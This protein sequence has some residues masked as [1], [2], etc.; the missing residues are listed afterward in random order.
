MMPTQDGSTMHNWKKIRYAQ[1]VFFAIGDT[2]ARTVGADP[3]SGPTT[4]AATSFDGVVWTNRELAS[5][6]SWVAVAFGNPYSN[7]RDSTVGKKTPMWIAIPNSSDKFNRIQ[8]GAR[9]LGRAIITAGKI[10]AIRLWDTG[11]GYTESPDVTIVDPFNTSDAIV[12]CRMGD[13]VLTNPTWINRGLGYRT[14]ST[15][16]TITG[17]GYADVVPAGKF[18]VINDLETYPGPGAQLTIQGLDSIYT[19]VTVTPIGQ[20]DRGL[21]A[22]VRV[23]PEI[24]NRD[25]LSHLRPMTIRTKFSQ[26]RITGHDFLDIGTGNF[27]E[28]NYPNLYS[29]FYTP[30]PENEI[31]EEDGGR[32]FYTS[33]DQS[34]N[35]RTGELFAVEQATGTV[36]ISAD[37]FDFSGL[38]ELRLGGIRVG[39]TGAVVR[40]FSTDPSFTEDSNNVVPTQRAIRAYLASRLSIGGSE[41]AV[42]S[43]VA[44]TVAVGPDVIGNVASL[45][46]IV[47]VRADFIGAQSGVSGSILAQTMFYKSF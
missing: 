2:G 28:T 9:A 38:T 10:A 16:I 8:T 46:N 40:E 25:N 37:F 47:P 7:L 5:E 23:S 45:K 17:D 43:F 15:R 13:S 19:L 39:G 32:V 1:G 21:A 22:L 31:V 11:S 6:Q 36:T 33:T 20:T 35:F 30:S 42:G 3:T 4:F 34:G 29:G 24:K 41:I 27:E 12:E 14:N 26:C 18:I 44:G